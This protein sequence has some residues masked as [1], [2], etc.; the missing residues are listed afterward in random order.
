MQQPKPK[1]IRRSL[2][3]CCAA[4]QTVDSMPRS[5]TPLPSWKM[6]N[7]KKGGLRPL[8]ML[9]PPNTSAMYASERP[10]SCA[11]IVQVGDSTYAA[12]SLCVDFGG[13][14]SHSAHQVGGLDRNHPPAARRAGNEVPI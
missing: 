11:T 12:V 4:Q 9:I 7:A 10:S 3:E 2:L 5:A 1:F 6:S 8:H 14:A 13:S